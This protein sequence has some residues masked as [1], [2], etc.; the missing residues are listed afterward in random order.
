M[1]PSH[2][3]RP[4]RPI[5]RLALL[6]LLLWPAGPAPAQRPAQSPTP[7]P[8]PSS[9]RPDTLVLER[10][11]REALARGDAASSARALLA[12]G[13]AREQDGSKGRALEAFRSGLGYAATAGDSALVATLHNELGVLH[14]SETR[15][16]SALTHLTRARALREALGDRAALGRVLN[17]LGATH[18][19]LGHYEQA[20][21][22]FV[23]AL[24]L[25]RESGDRRGVALV[26]ANIGKTYQDWGQLARAH[27]VLEEA[28]AIGDSLGDGFVQGYARHTLGVVLS[29]LGEYGRARELF[30][31]SL[32]HYATRTAGDSTTGWTLNTVALAQ[33]AIREGRP[34]EAVGM[35]EA[36]LALAER[37]GSV[38]G[39]ARALLYLGRAHRLLGD[40]ARA[41]EALARS[42]ELSR[43]VVQR[44]LALE[45]LAEL[46]TLQEAAGRTRAALSYLRA[47]Q[48]LR[49]T[50][51][52]QAA[53]QRIASLESRAEAERQSRENLRLLEAQRGQ[54]LV[55][56]RQ[57]TVVVLG[58]VTLALAALLLGLLVGFNRRGRARE[59]LLARTNAELG[60]ANAE[61]RSALAEV[62]TLKGLIPICAKC[63][64]VR[65]DR[66][67]WEAVET[68]VASRSEASFSH[69]ICS[70][71]GPELYGADWEPESDDPARTDRAGVPRPA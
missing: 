19:Q 24:A 68:Y 33:L 2:V 21:D 53:A 47:H 42:L 15:Y 7:P 46:A 37:A 67:F 6:A 1:P 23:P 50:I 51:F 29:D 60:S 40:G 55:I 8:A 3:R 39:Q 36:V 69:G 56:T 9:A 32:A 63:K 12:L 43:G 5:G 30:T 66:G 34:Q 54:A 4:H 22:A 48:A 28:V 38:R 11:L 70:D 64:K 16:D 58:A 57:R 14:W 13:E 20:L 59:A 31:Q 44:V 27:A 61:L 45:A 35:L 65:D 71:C 26:L 49:D 62:R 41:E 25:R 17:T 10:D 18:Y 52:D